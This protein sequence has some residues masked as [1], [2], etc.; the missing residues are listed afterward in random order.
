M[1]GSLL[2]KSVPFLEMLL[3][4]NDLLLRA[5]RQNVLL[6]ADGADRPAVYKDIAELENEADELYRKIRHSLSVTFITPIDRED[7]L[8][9]SQG[10]EEC[11]DRF[12]RL[13]TRL[14]SFDMP[15]MFFE[16]QRTA[17]VMADMLDLARD[18]LQGLAKKK[19]NRRVRDFRS[20]RE[21]CDSLL[22]AGLAEIM[23]GH[24]AS[25]MLTVLK[26]IQIYDGLEYVLRKATDLFEDIEEAVMKN[27]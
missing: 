4:Q 24:L 1:L 15:S 6:F 3:E 10:Q 2:P 20:L 11:L 18:M 9:I 23:D 16:A 27:V 17:A 13:G 25:D 21:E 14:S 7:I 8:H 22:A 19:D 5:A 26:W 12:Q